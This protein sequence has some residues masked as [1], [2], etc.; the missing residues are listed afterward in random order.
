MIPMPM[1]EETTSSS[2]AQP[3]AKPN[4]GC[5]C[6][7]AAAAVVAIL[8]FIGGGGGS[9]APE[10]P[11][12][13]LPTKAEWVQKASVLGGQGYRMSGVLLVPAKA[14]YQAVGQP[15]STQSIGGDDYLYWDCADG[16]IQVVA[17]DSLL[18]SQ[19]MIAGRINTY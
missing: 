9:N 10:T 11:E 14:L 3:Q 12:K 4:Y 13:H 18:Q 5:G 6:L 7:L 2:P 19:G 8:A 16:Q 15:S 1:G 17:P